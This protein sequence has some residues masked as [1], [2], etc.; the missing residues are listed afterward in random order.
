M[1]EATIKFLD[2]PSVLQLFGSRDQHLR[3]IR[4]S[5]NVTITHRDERV[6]ISGEERAVAKAIR[7]V[8]DLRHR[9]ERNGALHKEDLDEALAEVAG[10]PVPR[11]T[12]PIATFQKGSSVKPRTPGQ[13]KYVEAIRDH[14][15]V[16]ALGPAG[17]GKTYLAVAMAVEALLENRIGKIVLVRPAVEAG[18]QLG[19]LP[20]TLYEKINPYL[21]PMLDSL[22]EMME[23]NLITQYMATDVIEVVPLAFMRGRT[24]KNAFIILDEAQNTTTAQMKMFLTRMGKDSRMVI[25][26][27]I[28]QND[29]PPRVKSGLADALYRLR[30]IDGICRVELTNADIQR[31]PLVQKI[32]DAYESGSDNESSSEAPL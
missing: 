13:E 11:R 10:E 16:F 32:V 28:T 19:F 30:N 7:V 4:D 26:G 31:H 22:T 15:M 3:R 24:L 25:S 6:S 23:P 18:E 8:E 12:I 1:Y 29:L 2:H 21:R 20:G 5:L 17:T 9:I 27:D 14:N